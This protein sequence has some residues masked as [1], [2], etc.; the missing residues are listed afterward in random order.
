MDISMVVKIEHSE[1]LTIIQIGKK[2]LIA[3]KKMFLSEKKLR[4][5]TFPFQ[6]NAFPATK[7]IYFQHI[8]NLYVNMVHLY[9]MLKKNE[10]NQVKD[11]LKKFC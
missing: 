3:E 2:E 9:A 4:I 1:V 8:E 7:K 6:R 10:S 5:W 11:I